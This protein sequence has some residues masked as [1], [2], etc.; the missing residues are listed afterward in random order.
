VSRAPKAKRPK[1][2]AVDPIK[3]RVIRGPNAEGRWYWQA[4]VY[5]DATERTVWSGW[6]T[7]EQASQELAA[8]V[9]GGDLG[10][11]RRP[12]PTVETVGD[13]LETWLGSQAKRVGL[14][15]HT[16]KH[17]TA[18][19]KPLHDVIGA[20]RPDR[21]DLLTIERFRDT[22][23]HSGA[24]PATVAK[25]LKIL[26]IAWRWGRELGYCPARDLPKVAIKAHPVRS[27]Q[28]PTPAD[29]LGVLDHLDGWPYLATRLLFATG[30]RVGEIAV[31]RWEAVDL[32][33]ATLTLCGK[34]GPRSFPLSPDLAAMLRPRAGAPADLVLG[35]TPNMVRGHLGTRHLAAACARAGVPRFSPH[36][37]RRATVDALLRAGVDVGTAASLMGHTPAVM[38]AAYRQ[39]TDD[40]RRQAITAAALGAVPGGGKVIGFRRRAER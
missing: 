9:A 17:Y 2:L 36:G 25:E 21:V 22:R 29:V 27:R 11:A 30:A 6:A 38:L 26:G 39:A 34:T 13:V 23:M 37:L 10:G 35:V 12:D 33:R 20:V 32:Q 7:R 15:P 24:A 3:A 28:T 18:R 8:L 5:R 40:D 16:M 4:V 19:A 14:S 1:S 31:L